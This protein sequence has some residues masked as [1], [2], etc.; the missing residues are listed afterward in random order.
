MVSTKVATTAMR[1]TQRRRRQNASTPEYNRSIGRYTRFEPR[2]SHD[3]RRS[4]PAGAGIG[5]MRDAII[6]VSV[7]ATSIDTAI[8]NAIVMPKLNRNLPTM[9][10]MKATGRNTAISDSVVASTASPISLVAWIAAGNEIG[11]AHV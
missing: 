7:N 8:A 5:S 6:G 3:L 11:R 4:S 10:L 9:P 1:T 2:S